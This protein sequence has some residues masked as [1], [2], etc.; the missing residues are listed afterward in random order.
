MWPIEWH[1]NE[2]A[3]VDKISTDKARRAIAELLVMQ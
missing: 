2:F 3:A 1:L